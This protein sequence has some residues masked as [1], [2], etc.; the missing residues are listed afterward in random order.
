MKLKNLHQ[1]DI[2]AAGEGW[3]IVPLSKHPQMLRMLAGGYPQRLINKGICIEF[4]NRL[5]SALPVGGRR[6]LGE[7][8][9][10]GVTYDHSD[11]KD[12]AIAMSRISGFENAQVILQRSDYRPHVGGYTIAWGDPEVIAL[13][14]EKF[15]V[16][17]HP[18][19][20]R[21]F[22]F[23]ERA[24]QSHSK[25]LNRRKLEYAKRQLKWVTRNKRVRDVDVEEAN[26]SLAYDNKYKI[27]LGPSG[28]RIVP[29]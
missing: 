23:P 14:P 25:S 13:M 22:G 18:W 20:G 2:I 12:I 27:Q 29:I 6:S 26:K 15:A 9:M 10:A 17:D 28:Y 8:N 4:D 16:G 21:A 19:L 7:L 1:S 11:L 3:S 24:I 5:I